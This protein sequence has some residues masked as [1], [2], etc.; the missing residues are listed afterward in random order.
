MWEVRVWEVSVWEVCVGGVWGG[1]WCIIMA[2]N[3]PNNLCP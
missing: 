3:F 2:L 1:E